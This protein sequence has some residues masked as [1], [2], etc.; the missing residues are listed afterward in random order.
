MNGEWKLE[1]NPNICFPLT[2]APHIIL[3]D[4]YKDLFGTMLKNKT[5]VKN[6]T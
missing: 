5:Y 2:Y 3:H 4:T 1:T 6:T